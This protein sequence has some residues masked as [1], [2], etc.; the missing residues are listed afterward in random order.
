MNKTENGAEHRM[1]ETEN[2]LT[3]EKDQQMNSSLVSEKKNP[4]KKNSLPTV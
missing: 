1:N 4:R 3:E 2:S